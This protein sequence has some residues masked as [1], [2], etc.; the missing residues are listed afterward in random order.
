MKIVPKRR[1]DFFDDIFDSVFRSP[2]SFVSDKL[3]KMQTDLREKED[4]YILDIDLAGFRKED[5]NISLD[6]GYLTVEA[7]INKANDDENEHYIR[8]ERY[9][10]SCSRTYYVGDITQDDIKASY[11]NG[12]LTIIFPKEKDKLAGKQYILID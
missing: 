4:H 7:S 1:N 2:L 9:V 10:E 8:R 6:K 12:V 5:I 11:E 3:V